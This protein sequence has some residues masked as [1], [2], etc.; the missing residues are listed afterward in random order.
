MY[1]HIIYDYIGNYRKSHIPDG[2]GYQEKFYFTP[3][4]TGFTVTKTKYATIGVAI[5]WDQVCV[6]CVMCVMCMHFHAV[7][8][9]GYIH[10][11]GF[12]KLLAL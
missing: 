1:T 5:C 7:Y 6:M 3:G 10:Y 9:R 4:D 12:L 11:S 2:T 8:I